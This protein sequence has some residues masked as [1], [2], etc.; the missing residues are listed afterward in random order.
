MPGWLTLVLSYYG[1]SQIEVVRFRHT[2]L[3]ALCQIRGLP[4]VVT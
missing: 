1:W 3:N 2:N 4:Q